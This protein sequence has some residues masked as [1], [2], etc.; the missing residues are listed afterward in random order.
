MSQIPSILGVLQ[1]AFKQ[2][3]Q[4]RRQGG[5]QRPPQQKPHPEPQTPRESKPT[6]STDEE[7]PHLD[8]KA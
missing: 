3:V 4:P 2:R 5:Q 1:S 8:L 7:N 6:E